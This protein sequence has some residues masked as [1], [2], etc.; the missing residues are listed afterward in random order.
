MIE[1]LT[2]QATVNPESL[3]RFVAQ[4]K[5]AQFTPGGVLKFN[6][7][8]TQPEAIIEQLSVLLLQLSPNWHEID[9]KTR[10]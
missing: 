6:L 5:G 8:S 9:V 1:R 10:R 7:K 2:E 3:A 4:T